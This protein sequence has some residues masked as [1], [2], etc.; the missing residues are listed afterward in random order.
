MIF[1]IEFFIYLKINEFAYME[2]KY[3]FVAGGAAGVL[4]AF[5]LAFLFQNLW[6]GFFAALI[7]VA[8]YLYLLDR[9]M[10]RHMESPKIKKTIRLF[11]VLL[12][13]FQL[14]VSVLHYHRAEHQS[15]ILTDIRTIIDD[16]TVRLEAEQALNKTLHHYYL[17]PDDQEKTLES[18]FRELMDDRL[19][20][21]GTFLPSTEERN[22]DITFTWHAASPDSVIIT[23]VTAIS[24]GENPE[25]VNVNK[26]MGFYQASAILTP[27]G[28]N[29]EREN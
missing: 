8:I 3:L 9:W 19:L 24:K 21:D 27:G 12:L 22:S 13:G 6:V 16:T 14:Y 7:V 4:A 2:N 11:I 1:Q 17:K 18:M 25:F 28:V 29:Y 15:E 23:A 26:K 20:D 10:I 5:C